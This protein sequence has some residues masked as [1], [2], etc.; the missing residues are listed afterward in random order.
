[1]CLASMIM[2]SI[3]LSNDLSGAAHVGLFIFLCWN[4]VLPITIFLGLQTVLSGIRYHLYFRIDYVILLLGGI[5]LL[6]LPVR[7][8]LL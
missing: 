4:I 6:S 2:W 5:F 3:W 7:S 8:Y 1:M